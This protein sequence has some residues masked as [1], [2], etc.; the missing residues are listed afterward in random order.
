MCRK[1]AAHC[2][3]VI[4]M[5]DSIPDWKSRKKDSVNAPGIDWALGC[6]P[7]CE[8]WKDWKF[9]GCANAI[10]NFLRFW[11]SPSQVNLKFNYF[12]I[13]SVHRH[14]FVFF[15]FKSW[16]FE[17]INFKILGPLSCVIWH[18]IRLRRNSWNLFAPET[19][20][21]TG[22]SRR[23]FCEVGSPEGEGGL[24]D[25]DKSCPSS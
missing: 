2:S 9:V 13:I 3:G 21:P 24:L 19:C 7:D 25:I 16:I 4:I 18:L 6:V 14:Y 22:L 1:R 17:F 20:L 15:R 5:A 10:R 12:R 11:R 8:I 23:S